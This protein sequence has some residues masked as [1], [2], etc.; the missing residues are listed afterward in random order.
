[1]TFTKADYY[2]DDTSSVVTYTDTS[3]YGMWTQ[4]SASNPP[5]IVYSGNN[6]VETIDLSRA[7]YGTF[8]CK[9]LMA[10]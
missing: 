9:F 6:S 3:F 2:I 7:Y 8:T 1:L 5:D 10:E 4:A